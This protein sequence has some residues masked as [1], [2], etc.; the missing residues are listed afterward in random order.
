MRRKGT[1]LAVGAGGAKGG[2]Q[3]GMVRR[4]AVH[5]RQIHPMTHTTWLV[6]A[7]MTLPPYAG[8]TTH[9]SEWQHVENPRMHGYLR[10]V[11]RMHKDNSAA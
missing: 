5:T 8:C 3:C 4:A 2:F 10:G 9:I 7:Q 1:G 6:K 11:V